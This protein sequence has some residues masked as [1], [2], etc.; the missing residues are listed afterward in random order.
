M[1]VVARQLRVLSVILCLGCAAPDRDP[2][3]PGVTPP[4]VE[5]VAPGL[6]PPPARGD[7]LDRRAVLRIAQAH[8]DPADAIAELDS[9]RFAFALDDASIE[10][11]GREGV[12]PQLLDYL[13]KRA[14]VDWDALRGDVD[15]DVA[16]Q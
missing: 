3:D 14:A 4:G 8:A 6:D 5:V 12:D 15:P 13:R 2:E 16:P 10:W 7:A 1:H 11:F 9:R